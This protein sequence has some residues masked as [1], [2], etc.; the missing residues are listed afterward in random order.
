MNK[1]VMSLLI[2]LVSSFLEASSDYESNADV[3][4]VGTI[5]D[6]EIFKIDGVAL[7]SV[8]ID[9]V[10][11]SD[12]EFSTGLIEVPISGSAAIERLMLENDDRNVFFFATKNERAGY[13]VFSSLLGVKPITG[14]TDYSAWYSNYLFNGIKQKIAT[15][16]LHLNK[17]HNIQIE[18]EYSENGERAEIGVT[19]KV[20]AEIELIYISEIVK[21]FPK[22]NSILKGKK[23]SHKYVYKNKVNINYDPKVESIM[24]KWKLQE[25]SDE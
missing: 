5:L 14:A 12:Y 6:K 3:I 20:S 8:Q 7:I 17:A 24:E 18:I 16:L 22:R 1:I 11:R 23:I 19:G 10:L 9:N 15:D 4:F 25:G 13:L 2:I 21:A